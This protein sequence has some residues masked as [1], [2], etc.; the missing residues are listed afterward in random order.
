MD[1]RKWF[2]PLPLFN[3]LPCIY[4]GGPSDTSDHTPPQNLLPRPLPRDLQLMTVPACFR[5]NN[6]FSQDEMRVAAVL[7]T[8][9]FTAA[10][11]AAT[12][13]GGWI[14]EALERDR[15]LREFV[16]VR[17]DA[18][19]V[20]HP[21]AEVIQVFSRVM[22]KTAAGLLFYEFGRTIPVSE[23]SFITVGHTKNI[24]PSALAESCRRDDGG[25]AEVTKSGRELE[26][27]AIAFSGDEPP[28]MPDWRTYVPG[29]FEYLF[30]RRSS[31]T[32][33]TAVKLHD[34][35]TVILDSP[36]PAAA[37]PRRGG[38]PRR[39]TNR[40]VTRTRKAE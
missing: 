12:S 35:L 4:C 19:G 33:L 36:W 23:I 24:H 13:P 30:L 10:D 26:R 25:W 14:H 11:R 15:A 21:D 5:C 31:G 22:T 39:A 27:Q 40:P 32:L 28:H 38:R 17:L 1:P 34:A 37:G 9:S 7:C 8:V 29:Y 16:N 18:N 6:N 2:P 3:S 20:F